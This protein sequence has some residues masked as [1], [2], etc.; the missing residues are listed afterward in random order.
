MFPRFLLLVLLVATAG[1]E[2]AAYQHDTFSVSTAHSTTLLGKLRLQ[3]AFTVYRNP[4]RKIRKSLLL[5]TRVQ[6]DT[7]AIRSA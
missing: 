2:P 5:L 7:K 3:P 4:L 1:F 6:P